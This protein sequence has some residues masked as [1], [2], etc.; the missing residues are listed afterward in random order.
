MKEKSIEQIIAE[1]TKMP[2]NLLSLDVILMEGEPFDD[3][4]KEKTNENVT[5]TVV[6]SINYIGTI[7]R[8]PYAPISTIFSLDF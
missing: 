7:R 5:P 8:V 6:S 2:S 4:N 3:S 1:S